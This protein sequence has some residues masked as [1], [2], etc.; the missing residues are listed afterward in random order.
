MNPTRKLAST[1]RGLLVLFAWFCLVSSFSFAIPVPSCPARCKCSKNEEGLLKAACADLQWDGAV[2]PSLRV[3]ELKPSEVRVECDVT[4]RISSLFPQLYSVS[5][6]NCSLAHLPE[7]SFHDLKLLREID[8]SHNSFRAIDHSL[9]AA[10]T[11]LRRINL[12][13]NPL[14]LGLS[15]IHI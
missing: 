10:N 7:N 3:L 11:K 12:R 6:K 8:L 14:D 4:E 5:L 13:H 2:Y 9:F 1:R 15:L